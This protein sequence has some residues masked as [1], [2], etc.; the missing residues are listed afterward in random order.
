MSLTGKA[1]LKYNALEL[2][3]LT[4]L[5][6]MVQVLLTSDENYESYCFV[7]NFL[8]ILFKKA[9]IFDSHEAL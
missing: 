9:A 1:G 3:V 7:L 4:F 5:N 8:W 2:K 6:N